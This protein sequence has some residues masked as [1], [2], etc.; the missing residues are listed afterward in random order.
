MNVTEL[1]AIAPRPQHKEKAFT[2]TQIAEHLASLHGWQFTDGKI[3][4]T[5]SFKNYYETIAFVNVLAAISHATDH[6][7]DLAVHYNRCVVAFN[8]HDVENGKGGI[9]IN[10]F[11]CAA[12]IE[13][14]LAQNT[15]QH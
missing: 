7:P 4:K 8:T 3:V 6:H 2:A 9:S 14:F 10:D 13:A 15:I 12:R 1:A 11:I 5:F